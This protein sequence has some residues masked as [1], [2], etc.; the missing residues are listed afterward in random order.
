MFPFVP[1]VDEPM[2]SLTYLAF[3]AL[4]TGI[5]IGTGALLWWIRREIGRMDANTNSLKEAI[6]SHDAY[7]DTTNGVIGKIHVD[8][9]VQESSMRDLK[10]DIA[11]IK[12][13][14]SEI[15]KDIKTLLTR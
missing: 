7:I 2:S 5:G 14:L 13:D 8:L 11:E 3:W 9:A 1:T 6:S 10:A 4:I 15:N 12:R